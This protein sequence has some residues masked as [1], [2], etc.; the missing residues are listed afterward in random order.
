VIPTLSMTPIP[1]LSSA[2]MDKLGVVLRGALTSGRVV[3]FGS[4]AKGTHRP[5][6]DIDLAFHQTNLTDDEL[7][8]VGRLLEEAVFPYSIDVVNDGPDLYPP[9]KEHIAR[10][11][12][13]IY[14]V[15]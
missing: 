1:G 7:R 5:G 3:L 10:V 9:L 12:I 11:G 15:S 4:R 6:S 2:M 14:R 13:E 8:F